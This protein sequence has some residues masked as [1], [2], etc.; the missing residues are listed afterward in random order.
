MAAVASGPL[1]FQ[2]YIYRDRRVTETLVRR[3]QDAGY[4]ALCLTVDLPVLGVRER[5]IRNRFRLPEGVVLKNFLDVGLEHMPEDPT[6]SGL[7]AYF[8]KLQDPAVTWKDVEWLQSITSMP[9]LIKGILTR[10]DARLALEHGCQGIIVSNHGGRQLDGTPA[11]IEVLQEIVDA[12]GGSVEVLVDGAFRRG[13]DVLK[14]LS[15]GARAVLIGRPAIWG[16]AVGGE[17]G[18]LHVLQLLRDE[19]DTAMALAGCPTIGSIGR[20]L[21][22]R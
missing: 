16:L 17:A 3:A 22:R 20:H 6:G 14:A 10:E 12:V 13:T 15:L 5:D 1:W 11:P 8:S 7:N 4:Q 18:V 19:L 9:L 2:L 21:V